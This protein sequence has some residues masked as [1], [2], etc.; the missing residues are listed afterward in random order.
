LTK[1]PYSWLLS[2]Y[3]RPYHYQGELSSFSAFIRAPWK[4]TK[5]DSF[6]RD[7]ANPIEM[8]NTKNRRYLELL[9]FTECYNCTYE[10]LLASPESIIN[11]L[12]ARSNARNIGNFSN[13]HVSTKEKLRK[14]FDDY[15]DYYLNEKWREKLLKED[16]QYI[17]ENLDHAVM[18]TFSYE[19][20][21][22]TNKLR[23]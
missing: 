5:R 19:I 7:F 1:N 16:V 9:K 11:I 15:K 6:P 23:Q 2:L 14:N 18:S 20:L 17:N 21:G 13:I 12:C 22:S 8:W 10:G 4:V 3:K